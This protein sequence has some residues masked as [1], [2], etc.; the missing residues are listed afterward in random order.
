MTWTAT[1]NPTP[2]S[3][4]VSNTTLPSIVSINATVL[5]KTTKEIA[6]YLPLFLQYL[7]V[8]SSEIFQLV[9]SSLQLFQG[10]NELSIF[11]V[12]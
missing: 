12:F 7:G 4:E 10:Q 11:H 9:F 3:S 8:V 2:K 1:A 5:E 6:T